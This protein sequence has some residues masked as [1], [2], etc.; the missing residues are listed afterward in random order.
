[1]T[2]VAE[3]GE[4]ER[5][6][7]EEVRA[8]DP[9]L[10]SPFF[11]FDFTAAVA[12]VRRDVR[13]GVLRGPGGVVSGFLPFQVSRTGAGRP[14]GGKLSDYHGVIA[15]PQLE[16]SAPEVL[17]GCGLRSFAFNHLIA[18]Q[19][20]FRPYFASVAS[21]P[22]VDF[23]A[24][25][26]GSPSQAERKRQRLERRAVL[27]LELRDDST[28]AL[29]SLVAWK[30]AQYRRTGAFDAM[31]RPWVVEVLERL[32]ASSI[33]MLSCVY[34]DDV[35]I[36]AHLGLRS[37]PVLHWWFPAYDVAF[38]RDSPGL[39]QLRMLLDAAPADG[40]GV[41]D[42][43]KGDE[44]YKAAFANAAIEIGVGVVE[45][46]RFS[47]LRAGAARAAWRRALYS[48]LYRPTNWARKRLDWR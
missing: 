38:A 32:H 19:R 42:F 13:V 48:R 17:R 39:V 8:S 7:W 18:S 36:A 46:D 28:A 10:S 25:P 9:T 33:G 37:G 27:R 45:T 11:A 16:W 31:T 3:L 40:I 20:P 15:A 22:V 41:L 44:D 34:A 4:V 21:S 2:T 47:A 35:L 23:A 12:A 24:G 43:G 5:A 14:V 26:F 29:R 1:V 6:R 30:S